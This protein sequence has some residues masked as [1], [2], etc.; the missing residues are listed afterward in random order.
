MRAGV[1]VG[2]EV[3]TGMGTGSLGRCPQDIQGAS[4]TL[5]LE[6]PVEW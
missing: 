1:P 3:R 2:G 4:K 6:S 5:T